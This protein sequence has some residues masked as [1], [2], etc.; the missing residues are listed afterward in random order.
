MGG[1]ESVVRALS[2][3][4]HT[5]GCDVTVA[6]L[7]SRADHPFVAGLASRGV[8]VVP[9]VTH[10]RNYPRMYR[11]VARLIRGR[12][13]AIVHT[14]G[15][16]ADVLAAAAAR[17]A[18][19]PVISTAHGFTGGG[20][21]NRSYEALQ[22]RA[23][24]R[25]DAV[26]AVARPL[27]DRLVASGVSVGRV[28]LLRNAWAPVPG[29]LDRSAARRRLGLEPHGV[30]IGWVGRL[31]AEK[32]PDVF[33]GAL[34]H[35]GTTGVRGVVVGDGPERDSLQARARALPPGLVTL[36]GPVP[37]AGT[38]LQAFD[39]LVLSSRTEG[40]PVILLEGMAAGVP[41]VATAVG[42]V[43]DVVGP[44]EA[45]LVPPDSPA[46]LAAAVRSVLDRPDEAARRAEA[47]R[48]K[49]DE[50]FSADRWCR[51]HVDLYRAVTAGR[52]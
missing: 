19:V 9:V 12:R 44:A 40:T 5:T 13:T 32:G 17:R 28:V 20:W 31:S 6:A 4:L 26:I 1:L 35:L 47:A 22:R 42:G 30:T 45:L 16:L 2:G 37:D 18:R 41:I 24:R 39:A 10:H 7:V 21:R 50:V 29:M 38:C 34:E 14:H 15:Y 8:P 3:L 46:A 25:A 27:A 52:P 23:F 43:P 51:A 33:L 49:L 11:E 48:R 36:L